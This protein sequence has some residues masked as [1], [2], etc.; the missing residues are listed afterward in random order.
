MEN[1]VITQSILECGF[2]VSNELGVGFLESV[3]ENAMFIAMKQRGLV[4]SR[5]YQSIRP[6]ISATLIGHHLAPTHLFHL[7]SSG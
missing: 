6:R 5:L 7:R 4:D 2:E 1:S 3:Y